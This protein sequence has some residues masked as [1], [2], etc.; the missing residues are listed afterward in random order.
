MPLLRTAGV[1]LR[2]A[3]FCLSFLG[4]SCGPSALALMPGVINDPHNLSLRRA[5][6]AYGLGQACDEIRARSMP[7]RLGD[8]EPVSGRFFPTQCTSREMGGGQIAVQLG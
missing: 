3:C 6:L 8:G 5:M 1:R 4:A 2:V 7:L